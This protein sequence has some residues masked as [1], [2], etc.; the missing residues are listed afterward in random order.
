MRAFFF[1]LCIAVLPVS[2]QDR[3]LCLYKSGEQTSAQGNEIAWHLAKTLRELGFEPL[4]H[5]VSAGLPSPE[6]TRK[7][8]GVLSWFRTAAMPQAG[9]YVRWLADQLAEGR[10]VLVFGNFGAFQDAKTESWLEDDEVNLFFRPLGWQ[11]NGRY[12]EDPSV[13]RVER[14]HPLVDAAAH[15]ELF[16]KPAYYLEFRSLLPANL[17]LVVLSRRDLP[18]SRSTMVGVSPYGAMAL[19]PYFCS[20]SG[21]EL[22][23]VFSLKDFLLAGLKQASR[24]KRGQQR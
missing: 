22:A 8:L 16:E 19:S 11:F 21:G 3:V 4:Y 14:L 18:D 13:I 10:R 24:L 2:A 12:T 15:H 1:A 9:R 7:T 23:F 6:V 20:E 17:D 5:D